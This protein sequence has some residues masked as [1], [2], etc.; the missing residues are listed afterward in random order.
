MKAML[1]SRERMEK[2][3]KKFMLWANLIFISMG[4][5]NVSAVSNL[6]KWKVATCSSRKMNYFCDLYTGAS[7]DGSYLFKN[8]AYYPIEVNRARYITNALSQI[9][10]FVGL[11]F[12]IWW[13][14]V[15]WLPILW[16]NYSTTKYF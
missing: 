11:H 1:L 9:M 15:N 7:S 5:S 6:K 13:A 12:N 8:N 10:D 3:G 16:I 4:T 2:T 14:A